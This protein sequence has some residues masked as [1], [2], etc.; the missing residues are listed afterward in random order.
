[1]NAERYFEW[2]NFFDYLSVNRAPRFVYSWIEKRKNLIIGWLNLK[3]V[4]KVYLM[5]QRDD[6]TGE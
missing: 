4:P 1:M 2:N 6:D 3:G 5:T